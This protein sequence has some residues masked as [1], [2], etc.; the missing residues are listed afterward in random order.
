MLINGH[1][2]WIVIAYIYCLIPMEINCQIEIQVALV[3][4]YIRLT[5]LPCEGFLISN[6]DRIIVTGRIK[7][8]YSTWRYKYFFGFEIY[9]IGGQSYSCRPSYEDVCKNGVGVW[10][11]SECYCDFIEAP[12]MYVRF[13]K[14][15]EKYMNKAAVSLWW[16]KYS[17]A[18]KSRPLLI[19]DNI[20]DFEDIPESCFK[21]EVIFKYRSRNKG[22]KPHVLWSL[23]YSIL[24]CSVLNKL[25]W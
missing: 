19:A 25:M 20:S 21:N 3:G 13:N 4:K 16:G 9:G 1:F 5:D 10:K 24:I 11:T 2:L 14:T 6:L 12:Y 18:F 22:T 8:A 7:M 15:V 17:Y 23:A